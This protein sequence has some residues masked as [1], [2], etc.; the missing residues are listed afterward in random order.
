MPAAARDA[1]RALILTSRGT[2][3]TSR[4]VQRL[5]RRAELRVAAC[6][7]VP[8]EDKRAPTPHALRHTTATLLLAAGW[9][10]KM[11]RDLLGHE[12]ITTVSKY[13][14]KIPGELAVA[15]AKHPLT[16]T[17]N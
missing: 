9:D 2:R 5:L 10:V 16:S 8:A 4:D 6:P 3:I 11:V 15:I 13:L 14:D 1:E 7:E 12:S 17:P